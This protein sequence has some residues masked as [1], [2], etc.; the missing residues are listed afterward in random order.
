M[1]GFSV[2]ELQR[3]KIL[4]E[5]SQYEPSEKDSEKSKFSFKKISVKMNKDT[6]SF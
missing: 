3:R 4:G 1:K 5:G 2:Y 6:K